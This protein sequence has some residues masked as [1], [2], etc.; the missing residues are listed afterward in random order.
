MESHLPDHVHRYVTAARAFHTDLIAHAQRRLRL[1]MNVASHLNVLRS[2][3]SSLAEKLNAAESSRRHLKLL[4]QLRRSSHATYGDFR[5]AIQQIHHHLN[6]FAP[7][8]APVPTDGRTPR[9]H[10]RPGKITLRGASSRA[11]GARLR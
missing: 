3:H 6:R 4:E 5:N 9:R 10:R 7:G 2:R 1:L 8:D 11:S